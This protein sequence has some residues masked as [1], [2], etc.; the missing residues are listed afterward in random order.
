MKKPFWVSAIVF[1]ITLIFLVAVNSIDIGI[2]LWFPE[3]IPDN[4]LYIRQMQDICD[5]LQKYNEV[6][7]LVSIL[8][9]FSTGVNFQGND[10]L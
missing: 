5:A 3:G 8:S 9:F 7:G 6:D 4:R 10:P 2:H 1:G